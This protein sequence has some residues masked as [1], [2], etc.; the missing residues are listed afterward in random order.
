MYSG[1]S[2]SR[3]SKGNENRFEKSGVKLQRGISQGND[4]YFEKSGGLKKRVREIAILLVY[5][6]YLLCG[7]P[8]G[9]ITP[10]QK[11]PIIELFSVRLEG[12][13]T[14]KLNYL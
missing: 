14:G 3:T 7:S 5:I 11:G 10:F 13:S 6:N 9:I 4:F 1:I 2:F 8:I 12:C